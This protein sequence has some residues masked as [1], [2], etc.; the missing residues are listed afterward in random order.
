M[1]S[2]GCH[3]FAVVSGLVC[4]RRALEPGRLSP[5]GSFLHRE[6]N[7]MG[8]LGMPE[9]ITFVIPV[10]VLFLVVYGAVRLALKHD[11]RSQE[12]GR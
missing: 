3:R 1:A 5:I 8:G 9:L 12:R 10:I 4:P 6:G 11:R 7:E 2:L